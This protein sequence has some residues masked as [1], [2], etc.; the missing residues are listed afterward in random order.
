M[1]QHHDSP[2]L[3]YD[4]FLDTWE[5]TDLLRHVTR[6]PNLFDPYAQQQLL[7]DVSGAG[8]ITRLVRSKGYNRMSAEEAKVRRL[9]Y[10]EERQ[11]AW[12][13]DF[14][15]RLLD[16]GVRE[17]RVDIFLH[18]MS[19]IWTD[20]A[21]RQLAPEMQRLKSA[22]HQHDLRFHQRHAGQFVLSW[23]DPACEPLF[24]LGEMR[25]VFEVNQRMLEL[26][27]AEYLEVLFGEREG[28]INSLYVRRGVCMP[29][30]PGKHLVEAHYLSSYSLASG[31][32][33]LFAQTQGKRQ[34]SAFPCIFSGPVPAIQSRVVAFAPFIADMKLD[35]MEFV[36]AP[37]V[38]PIA[39]LEQDLL[40][41][42]TVKIRDYEFA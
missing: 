11:A 9:D 31:T 10:F 41:N 38:E 18:A 29:Q 19:T 4:E 22:I 16:E 34:C 20:G 1:H 15:Q 24:D 33:E 39:L 7:D 12:S 37:P 5:E 23:P 8:A 32:V 35:Q 17:D 13:Q 27:M 2:D 26:H 6:D 42:A 30:P 40:G 3:D 36:V 21:A 14:R 25:T 28:S